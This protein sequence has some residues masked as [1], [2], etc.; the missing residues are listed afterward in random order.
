MYYTVFDLHQDLLSILE[1]R[2]DYSYD[3]CLVEQRAGTKNK[4]SC[5]DH[6]GSKFGGKNPPVVVIMKGSRA[7][8]P[9]TGQAN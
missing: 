1:L 3:I 9:M 2:S 4:Q 7:L 6:R 5:C 8:T